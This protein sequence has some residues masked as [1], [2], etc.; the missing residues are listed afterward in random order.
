[1]SSRRRKARLRMHLHSARGFNGRVARSSYAGPC[2]RGGETTAKLTLDRATRLCEGVAGFH[3]AKPEVSMQH[4]VRLLM[5]TRG[6][7][8]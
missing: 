8:A 1:M 5:A 3:P 2:F 7:A 4:V 6:C